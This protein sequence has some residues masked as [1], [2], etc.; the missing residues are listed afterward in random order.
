M[1]HDLPR[2][3][4]S[5][6]TYRGTLTTMAQDIDQYVRKLDHFEWMERAEAIRKLEVLKAE[7][8][9]EPIAGHLQDESLNVRLAAARALGKIGSGKAVEPLIGALDDPSFHVRQ[10]AMWSL[11]EIGA[12]AEKALP[13]LRTLVQSQ[14]RYLQAELSE[15]EVAQLV[16]DRIE[17]AVNEAEE[18][19][20]KAEEAQARAR[21]EAA[22]AQ[23]AAQATAQAGAAAP[24]REEA[25]LAEEEVEAEEAA[26]V[27]R[28]SPEEIK[29]MR[30]AALARHRQIVAKMREA[31]LDV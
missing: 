5:N 25:A 11:G 23:E 10:V 6:R 3:V 19:R 21:A 16:V 18:A 15:A 12:P 8:A 7:S 14:A 31:G 4:A 13:A 20:R 30:Q 29:E 17:Q 27:A 26:A 1:Y 22:A 24:S 2:Q 9:V 28:V